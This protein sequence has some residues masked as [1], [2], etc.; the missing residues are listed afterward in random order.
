[1]TR[2][3][4]ATIILSIE[5]ICCF[6]QIT[7]NDLFNAYKQ[8]LVKFQGTLS[9]LGGGGNCASI[10]LIKSA[11]GTF[12]INGVFKD[13]K[14]DSTTK[15]VTVVLRNDDVVSLSFD[16][17][18]NGKKYF[19]IKNIG[20]EKIHKDIAEYSRFCFAIMC[21]RQQLKMGYDKSHFYR[22]VDRLNKGYSASEIYEL[23]G[24][25][26]KEINDLTHENLSKFK[27]IVLYNSPHAVY[28]SYGNYDEFF[29]GTVSGIEPLARLNYFHCKTQNGCPIQGA[30]VLE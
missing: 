6:G 13:V 25:R 21:R 22:A 19:A 14:S 28:S 30:Y 7:E 29:R 17:L 1:M 18:S 26:K 3:I 10:A 8:D 9:K 23:L 5:T 4:I 27:N 2:I 15:T 20:N 12:G 24:L 11:I 16:R